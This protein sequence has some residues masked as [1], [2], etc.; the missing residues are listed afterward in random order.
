MPCS[1]SHMRI[2]TRYQIFCL[3]IQM[4]CTMLFF[5]A[6]SVDAAGFDCAKAKT[7]NE[8]WICASE[9]IS[10]LDDNMNYQ[11]QNLL[12]LYVQ[13]QAIRQW[14][15]EWLKSDQLK[16]QDSDCLERAYKK[17]IAE[18]KSA[19]NAEANT[20]GYTGKYTRI[21]NGKIDSNQADLLLIGLSGQ[22]VFISGT[23]IW[24]NPGSPENVRTGEISGY[25][26][27]RGGV[28]SADKRELCGANFQLSDQDYLKVED[29]SGCGGMN[30]TFNGIYKGL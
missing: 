24:K 4:F 30:V 5:F 26:I 16:C 11:Y 8:K 20:K 27:L 14:Q 2:A 18:L 28:V 22:R 3:K 1:F 19:N 12:K 25:G 9:A 7:K 10:K 23:S 6:G 29:E 17:R 15:K 13:N 21:I